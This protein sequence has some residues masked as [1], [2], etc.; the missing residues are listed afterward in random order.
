M[1]VNL[2][3]NEWLRIIEL[4]IDSSIPL[5]DS[6]RGLITNIKAQISYAAH[7]YPEEKL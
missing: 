4:V 1:Q 6:D 5:T 3:R 7:Y 2:T